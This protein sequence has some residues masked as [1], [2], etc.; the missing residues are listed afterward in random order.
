MWPRPGVFRLPMLGLVSA[1]FADQLR[2]RDVQTGPTIAQYRDAPKGCGSPVAWVV[3]TQ[4]KEGPGR[5]A[6][7]AIGKC[8][9]LRGRIGWYTASA[10]ELMIYDP[11]GKLVL[12][13]GPSHVEGYR[14]TMDGG[15]PMFAGGRT[16]MDNG[17]VFEARRPTS[18]AAP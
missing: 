6:A 9:W 10:I 4:P 12:V 7:V 2:V 11:T 16:M 18:A 8:Q 3:R 1:M 17:S 15:K 14:W 13:S 5:V